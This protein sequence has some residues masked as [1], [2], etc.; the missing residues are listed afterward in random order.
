[1]IILQAT[2]EWRRWRLHI[3]LNGVLT[4]VERPKHGGGWYIKERLTVPWPWRK[5]K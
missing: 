2:E 1:M 4:T 5:D 3:T